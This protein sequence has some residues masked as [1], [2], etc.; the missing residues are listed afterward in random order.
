MYIERERQKNDTGH[1]LEKID[2]HN[3]YQ[4]TKTLYSDIY[5][6]TYITICTYI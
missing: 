5:I 6:Y 4:I 1:P 2:I 3:N